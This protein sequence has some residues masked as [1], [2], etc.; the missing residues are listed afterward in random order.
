MKDKYSG[1]VIKSVLLNLFAR[2]EIEAN[3]ERSKSNS[4]ASLGVSI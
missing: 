3:K 4:Y 2:L 1:L